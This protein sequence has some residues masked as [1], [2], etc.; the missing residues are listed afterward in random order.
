MIL[1]YC[2]TP[3]GRAPGRAALLLPVRQR[4]AE[5]VKKVVIVHVPVTV[6]LGVTGKRGLFPPS[7]P[8]F[9]SP[10]LMMRESRLSRAEEIHDIEIRAR[11]PRFQ[12][13]FRSDIRE[14]PPTPAVRVRIFTPDAD[15]GALQ[16]AHEIVSF[17]ILRNNGLQ[18]IQLL[19]E[20][21]HLL[22]KFRI[23]PLVDLQCAYLL[24]QRGVLFMQRLQLV[25]SRATGDPGT[26]SPAGEQQDG[27][28]RQRSAPV[29]TKEIL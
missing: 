12:T 3:R 14:A 1:R 24:I 25:A 6:V 5:D 26:Y 9:R 18:R 2:L 11:P 21:V 8:N 13:A 17:L 20:R 29:C 27:Q 19:V 23:A 7:P 10:T 28:A 4:P 15:R 16:H 22:R